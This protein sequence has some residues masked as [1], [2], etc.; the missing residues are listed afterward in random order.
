MGDQGT[1][2][3]WRGELGELKS[4]SSWSSKCQGERLGNSGIESHEV[5]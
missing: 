3:A 2:S 5:F 4:E 1:L